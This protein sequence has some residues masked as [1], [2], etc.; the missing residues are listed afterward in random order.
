MMNERILSLLKQ[1]R[2]DLHEAKQHGFSVISCTDAHL[3]EFIKLVVAECAYHARH[4]NTVKAVDAEDVAQYIE[5]HFKV[6]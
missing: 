6:E 4:C 5:Q 2:I 3:K 1:S